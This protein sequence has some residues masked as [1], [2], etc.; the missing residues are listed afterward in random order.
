VDLMGHPDSIRNVSL[1][2]HLH[3]GKTS[4]MDMLIEQ[5]HPKLQ[6][7]KKQIRYTDTRYDEQQRGLSIKSMSMS[8]VMQTT[9]DKS[10]LLNVID[11]PGHVNFNDEVGAA[12]RVSDGAVIV[13]DAVEG[14]SDSS[15]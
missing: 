11:A 1:V 6:N 5:T 7:F 8:L 12:L 15:I 10:Y 14:V 4:F 13:V 3:H 9:H 2:G